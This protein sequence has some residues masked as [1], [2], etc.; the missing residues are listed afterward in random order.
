MVSKPL[1]MKLLITVML[2]ICVMAACATTLYMDIDI[3]L[4]SFWSFLKTNW[5][6]VALFISE[7][8]A[9]LPT[10]ANG[11]IQAVIQLFSK[12]LTKPN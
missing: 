11:I 2:L 6:Y 8:A 7:A 3:S 9:L 5:S 1:F 12:V 4:P 10:K